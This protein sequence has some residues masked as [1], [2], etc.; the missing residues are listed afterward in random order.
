MFAKRETQVL[1]VGAGPVGLFAAH[2]FAEYQLPV[3]IIDREFRTASHSY[4]LALH[5]AT[6]EMLDRSGITA[7]LLDRGRPVDTVA[8]YDGLTCRTQVRLADLPCRY[9][10]LLVLPQSALEAVLDRRLNERG[11]KVGWNHRAAELRQDGRQVNVRVDEMS[12][13]SGGYAVATTQWTIERSLNVTTAFVVGAD[14]HRS[15]V[16]QAMDIGY[17]EVAPVASFA[18]F[19]FR[20]DFDLGKEVRVILDDATTNVVWPLPGDRVRWSFQLN[21]AATD[22]DSRI[23]S[24]LAVHV[25]SETYP[26]LSRE[27]L[28]KL[29]RE[30]APWFDGKIDEPDWSMVVRFEHRLADR[31]GRDRCWLAG[32]AAHMTGPVGVQGVN[33]GMREA[34][35]LSERIVRVIRNQAS[36]ESLEGYNDERLAEWRAMFGID[37]GLTPGDTCDPWVRDRVAR[38]TSCLPASGRHLAVLGAQLG[39][40]APGPSA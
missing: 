26:F 24:R 29:L 23:K 28:E 1:I 30:R 25:D 37:R 32:D 5:G 6:L 4:A 35:D 38:L 22:L 10:F 15:L 11:V 31:F 34:R 40:T 7:E 12:K 36:A 8:F 14:G 18:V 2:T 19:E 16:R 9:P 17:P 21:E 33:V 20:T 13:A 39:L 3:Q 27:H